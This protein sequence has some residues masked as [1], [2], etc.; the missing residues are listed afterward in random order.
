MF[1]A[2]TSKTTY[3]KWHSLFDTQTGLRYSLEYPVKDFQS[4]DVTLRVES[5][6]AAASE[7]GSG[8]SYKAYEAVN[9]WLELK[10]LVGNDAK[11]H[12][13]IRQST[14]EAAEKLL[15]LPEAA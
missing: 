15:D 1:I 14:Q 7:Y 4:T 12:E 13:I 9:F 6:N 11:L 10:Q 5:A 8:L 2:T 3:W